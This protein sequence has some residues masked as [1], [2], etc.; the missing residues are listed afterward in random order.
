VSA[1]LLRRLRRQRGQAG[2][3]G[4]ATFAIWLIVTSVFFNM[5]FFLG[6]AMLVQS[7]V[8]RAAL[9]AASVGC[10]PSSAAGQ[11]ESLRHLGIHDL[12]VLAETPTQASSR[13]N[14][15]PAAGDASTSYYE[16]GNLPATM[17][18]SAACGAAGNMSAN[19]V[20]SG[21]WIRVRASYQQNLWI[22]GTREVQRSALVI[23]HS[24]EGLQ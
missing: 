5:V 1:R 6:S 15:P 8:N 24:Q 16:P 18:Y 10:L 3:E 12:Q 19:M 17:P 23:S 9:Q 13:T 20:P 14:M 21:G 4:I 22:F 11:L 7:N 2:L